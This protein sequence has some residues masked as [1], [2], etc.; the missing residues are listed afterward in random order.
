MVTIREELMSDI[1]AREAM[2]DATFGDA[3]SAKAAEC[4][5]ENRLPAAALVA[6]VAQK[7]S[8]FAPRRREVTAPREQAI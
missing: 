1:A 6:I 3:R 8:I 7:G 5:R 2:L 4:P